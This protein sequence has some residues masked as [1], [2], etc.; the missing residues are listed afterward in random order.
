MISIIIPM[1]NTEN[2]IEKCLKSVLDQSFAD[3]EVI[4]INDG[5]TDASEAIV[6]SI[7]EGDL[8]V[9]LFSQENHGLVHARKQGIRHAT[10]EYVLFVDA[11]DWISENAVEELFKLASDNDADVVASGATKA[12]LF[13]NSDEE[14]REE[15]SEENGSYWTFLKEANIAEPGLYRG[16]KLEELKRKLFCMEETFCLALLPYLWNKLWKR[17]LIER[18]VLAADERITVGEDVAIGFPAILASESLVVTNACFYF[19]RQSNA[20][21]LKTIGD[22]QAEYENAKRLDSYLRDK[23]DELGYLDQV[24]A[25][26]DRF[27][28]NQVCTRAYSVLNRG[29]E[30]QGLYPFMDQMPENLVIYGAGELG[31]AVYR[32]AS[33]KTNVKAWID[34]RA[35]IYQRLG[36]PVISINE[37]IPDAQ[38]TIV[39]AVFRKKSVDAIVKDLADK[40]AREENIHSIIGLL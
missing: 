29:K 2:Y 3:I 23:C 4:V 31:K 13:E 30:C 16:E 39:V 33:G 15:S 25:G 1:Y 7:A 21:M 14:F 36:M 40:G 18:F 28:F 17:E 37:Y 5:S 19:Y 38:D 24:G 12:Y 35:D 27:L 9:H 20:S 32:Y 8:R 34:G 11:D 26:L 10:G 6:R 22:E